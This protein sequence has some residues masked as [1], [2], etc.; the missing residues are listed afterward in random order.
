MLTRRIF[1]WGYFKMPHLLTKEMVENA[2]PDSVLFTGE[3]EDSP[4]GLHLNR[5]GRMVRYVVVRRGIPDWCVYV[6][7]ADEMS[8]EDIRTG[9]DKILSCTAGNII[10]AD[11]EVWRLYAD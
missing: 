9:G 2:E 3:I 1:Q 5:T 6:G 7:Y 4:N 11:E 10:D 8:V